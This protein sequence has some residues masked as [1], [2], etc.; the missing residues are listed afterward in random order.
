MHEYHLPYHL[1]PPGHPGE[2][3]PAG[4]DDESP[5]K[6]FRRA[7]AEAAVLRAR[8]CQQETQ[9]GCEGPMAQEAA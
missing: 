5:A 4:R 7:A 9:S 2:T 3:R 1:V 6:T 8:L